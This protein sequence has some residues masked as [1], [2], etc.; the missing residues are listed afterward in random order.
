M[1]D[2][3][4]I[5]SSAVR[6]DPAAAAAI[7]RVRDAGI[8]PWR[9]MEPAVGREVYLRRAL[10]FESART[11]TGDVW[12]MTTPPES[13]SLAIRVYRPERHEAKPLFVYLHGGG[14]TFGNLD[15]ADQTCRRISRAADC[16]VVSAAYRLAPEH[17]YP[18]PLDDAVAVARWAAIHAT[19]LGGDPSRLVVGGDSAGGN[20]AAGV[21]LRLR[22]EG[23]PRVALQVLIFPAIR[24]YFDTLAYHENADG[25]LLTRADM[26]WFWQNY[27]GPAGESQGPFACPGIADD[28]R[29]LPPAL[30]ITA[31]FDPLRDEGEVYGY[32]LRNA[33]VPAIIRR[34]PGMVHNFIAFPIENA[35]ERA[36]S[37]IAEATRRAALADGRR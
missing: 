25:Y 21:C 18:A 10:L 1:L 17:P 32:R 31:G 11:S 3:V 33:G 13:G 24:P 12:D 15:T 36:V 6:L 30:I 14:W 20:L 9:S 5:G 34:F 19:E 37:V 28:L 35:A 27:L 29:D 16:V 2:N 4:F 22:A 8:P 7:R 23:G 26:M